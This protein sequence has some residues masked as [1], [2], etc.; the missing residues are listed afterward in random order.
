MALH[1]V[2]LY[3]E[4]ST[5]TFLEHFCALIFEYHIQ[6]KETWFMLGLEN[7]VLSLKKT[8]KRH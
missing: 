6:E 7:G 5:K 4:M 1:L 3:D 2:G 8:L